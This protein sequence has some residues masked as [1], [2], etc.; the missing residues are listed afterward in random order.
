MN[1]FFKSK[2][3]PLLTG[4]CKNHST[5]NTL[6]NMIEKWKHALNKDKNVSTLLMDL[7]KAFDTLNQ[8]ITW[9]T[10]CVWLFV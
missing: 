10:K 6:L 2:F 1:L 4:F 3:S 8:F 7:T 5:Q 9:Q